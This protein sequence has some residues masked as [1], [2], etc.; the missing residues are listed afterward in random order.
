ML[1]M[2]QMLRE[3]SSNENTSTL[4]FAIGDEGAA[5]SFCD[6]C[7]LLWA[8]GIYISSI[9]THV[10]FFTELT[11]VHIPWDMNRLDWVLLQFWDRSGNRNHFEKNQASCLVQLIWK[12]SWDI[13]IFSR[14]QVHQNYNALKQN[15]FLT[16]VTSLKDCSNGISEE[17]CL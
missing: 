11:L 12:T 8:I 4:L 1:T 17:K 10:T 16:D 7:D 3:L 13:K 9:S 15:K 5:L 2:P 6:L 14:E